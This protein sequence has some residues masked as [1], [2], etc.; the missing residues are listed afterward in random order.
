MSSAPVLS[1]PDFAFPFFVEA[2]ASGVGIGAVLSQQGHPI[3]FY[4]QKLSHRMHTAS[5]TILKCL[6]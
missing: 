2:D 6:L 3:V 5:T 1:L 4:S